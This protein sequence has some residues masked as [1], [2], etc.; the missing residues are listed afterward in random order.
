[1]T[2]S[3][4]TRNEL[5]ARSRARHPAAAFFTAPSIAIF[6]AIPALAIVAT[7]PAHAKSTWTPFKYAIATSESIV[8]VKLVELPPIARAMPTPTKAT[9]DVVQVLKGH[10]KL[11]KQQIEFEDYPIGAPG[12]FIAFLDT[13][14]VWRFTARPLTGRTV[15]SD[16]LGIEAFKSDG[17]LVTPGLTTLQQLKTYL[18]DGTLRYSMEGPIC[19]P[20]RGNPTWQASRIRISLTY[21]AVKERAHVTGLPALAGLLAEP[22]VWINYDG[23]DS[24]VHLIYSRGSDRPLQLQGLVESLDPKSGTMSARFVVNEPIVLDAGTLQ[25]YLA[26]PQLR[27]CYHKCRLHCAANKQYPKLKD[28]VL[29]LNQGIG[30]SVTL[31][32]WDGGSLRIETMTMG[33]PNSRDWLDGDVPDPIE[34]GSADGWFLRMFMPPNANQHLVL[35]FDVGKPPRGPEIAQ[36]TCKNALVYHACSA[37]TRGA[38]QLFDGK[39]WQTVT[40]FTV[41]LDPLAFGNPP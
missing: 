25:K 40:T 9:L 3:P 26:D 13:R 7:S 12:E 18:K 10:L 27:H 32:G 19:F 17:N 37:H 34:R 5:F 22:E 2:Q 21:D 35:A 14:R 39:T 38:V 23:R 6:L 15:E 24:L 1:M 16:L 28:L 11:G 41:D 33:G 29:T 31:D 30:P 4:P 20:K 36:F 8:I